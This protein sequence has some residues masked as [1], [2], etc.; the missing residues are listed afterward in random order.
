VNFSIASCLV[1]INGFS[2][3]G[4]VT[5]TVPPS[6]EVL[7][8]RAFNS[9]CSLCSLDFAPGSR[10]QII[11]GFSGTRVETVTFPESVETIGDSAFC[12]CTELST[13]ILSQAGV[14]TSFSGFDH[15]PKLISIVMG[16]QEWVADGAWKFSVFPL[17]SMVQGFNDCSLSSIVFPNDIEVIIGFNRCRYLVRVTFPDSGKLSRLDGFRSAGLLTEVVIP[18]SLESLGWESFSDCEKLSTVLLP[19][20]GSLSRIDGLSNIPITDIVIPDSVELITGLCRCWCLRAVKFGPG[21]QLRVIQRFKK[22]GLVEIELPDSVEVIEGREFESGNFRI[23]KVGEKS[24]LSTIHRAS[25]KR[26]FRFFLITPERRLSAARQQIGIRL[27]NGGY[28][29]N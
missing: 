5:F 11:R 28:R 21:S 7:G 27:S 4:F 8:Y 26:P 1:E 14:L 6:V 17:L 25:R 12:D 19:L 24:R 2:T 23:M 3:C 20:D 29:R 9:C 18:K 10:L 22:C 15:C 16:T 13:V